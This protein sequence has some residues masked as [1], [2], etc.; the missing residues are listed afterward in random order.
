M[1]HL[2]QDDG[3]L[4]LWSETA[5]ELPVAQS[6]QEKLEV[7][8]LVV[9]AGYTG[10]STALHLAEQGGWLE[11][12]VQPGFLAAPLRAPTLARYPPRRVYAAR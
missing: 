2:P 4:S 3:E 12:I 6:L 1:N 9:G 7:D 10:L 5:I 8:V 11:S